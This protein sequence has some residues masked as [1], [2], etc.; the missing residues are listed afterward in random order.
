MLCLNIGS[1][2]RPFRTTGDYTW[3]NVDINPKWK[4][5]VVADGAKLDM[6]ADNSVDFIVSHHVLEHFGCGE[7][8]P[9]IREFNRILKPGGV[10]RVFV[11]DMRALA[12]GW[13]DGRIDTQ[14]YMTN[15]YGAYM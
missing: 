2:Q 10:L 11:P 12:K 6:Y 15:V 1:G 14:V 4:P 3:V 7:A 9:A 13:I 8:A 5:D